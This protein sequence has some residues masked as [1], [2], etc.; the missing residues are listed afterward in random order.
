MNPQDELTTP[1]SL[2][3]TPVP[4]TPNVIV[5]VDDKLRI[6]QTA[7]ASSEVLGRPSVSMV[8]QSILSFLHPDDHQQID[9]LCEIARYRPGSKPS[10]DVRWQLPEGGWKTLQLAICALPSGGFVMVIQDL[11]VHRQREAIYYDV[12]QRTQLALQQKN[13]FLASMSHEIRTPL[14]STLGFIQVLK[15]KLHD[16]T[17]EL[18]SLA[19]QSGDRLLHILNSVLALAQLNANAVRLHL[20]TVDVIAEVRQTVALLQPLADRKGL[21]LEVLSP[22]YTYPMRTDAHLLQR[23]VNNLVGNAI[24]FTQDGGVS[25]SLTPSETALVIEVRDTGIGIAPEFLPHIF[26][27]FKHATTGVATQTASSGL[28]L[29][30]TRQLIELMGGTIEVASTPGLGSRF[31]VRLPRLDEPR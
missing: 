21:A 10:L 7:P 30:I 3:N 1:S 25:V 2:P 16:E 31:T 14:T 15:G 17:L 28:G 8:A 29:A 23:I 24:K 22:V 27:E 18:L 26:D 13:A 19:E 6:T 20:A 9:A 12:L 11:A 4:S 5:F